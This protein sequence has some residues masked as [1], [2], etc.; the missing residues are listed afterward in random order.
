M[1]G[2]REQIHLTGFINSLTE[3]I[4][5]IKWDPD[6]FARVISFFS[7]DLEL[8]VSV[9]APLLK[10]NLVVHYSQLTKTNVN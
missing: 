2:G 5:I 1:F 6:R 3:L 8:K 4:K 7:Q 10:M 9:F